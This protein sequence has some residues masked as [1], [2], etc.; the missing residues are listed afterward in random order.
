MQEPNPAD[1]RRTCLDLIAATPVCYLTTLGED[2][3]PYT[4]AIGNLRCAAEFPALAEFQ[5]E[6]GGDLSLFMSTDM[7]SEKIARI[8]A[9]PKASAYLCD[10]KQIVG[11]M[12]G[13]RIEIVQNRQL[14]SRLWQK[15]WTLFFPSGPEGPEYGIIKLVPQMARGWRRTEAFELSLT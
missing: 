9:N 7:R 6:C 12:L 11:F 10:P 15:D 8:R 3:Y 2:G 5:A 4:T 13:G 1:I 14:K